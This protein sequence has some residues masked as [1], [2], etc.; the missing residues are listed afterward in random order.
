MRKRRHVIEVFPLKQKL[1]LL[2]FTF[3]PVIYMSLNQDKLKFMKNHVPI[4]FLK[5]DPDN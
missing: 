2:M 4:A 3:H 1:I 5:L